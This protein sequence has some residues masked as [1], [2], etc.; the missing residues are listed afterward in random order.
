VVKVAV[1]LALGITLAGN[2]EVWDVGA[3][4]RGAKFW[5]HVLTELKNRGVRRHFHPVVWMGFKGFPRSDGKRFSAATQCNC[6]GA[7]GAPIIELRGWKERKKWR[8]HLK[9]IYRA[10]TEAEASKRWGFRSQMG[11]QIPIDQSKSWRTHWPELI[12]F[13]KIPEDIRKPLHDPTPSS[14]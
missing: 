6:P 8:L 3:K 14:S 7:H 9:R 2:K 10:A 5:L 4:Q 11:P 12:T 1:Y 13:L